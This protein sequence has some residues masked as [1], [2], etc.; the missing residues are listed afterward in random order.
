MGFGFEYND[1]DGFIFKGFVGNLT[2]YA[3]IFDEGRRVAYVEFS[4]RVDVYD[5][6]TTIMENLEIT[7]FDRMMDFDIQP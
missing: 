7:D 3:A 5:L 1:N 2:S 6:A 4:K